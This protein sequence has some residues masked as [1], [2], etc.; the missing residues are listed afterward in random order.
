MGIFKDRLE[1]KVPPHGIRVFIVRPLT[2]TPQFL[3]TSRHITGAYSIKSLDWDASKY[4]LSGT[5]ETVPGAKYS[6]FIYL[7]T[8]VSVSRVDANADDLY[9]NIIEGNLLELSF[10]GQEEPV[11]WMVEFSK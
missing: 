4:S 9:H 5:S 10:M 7:P 11:N 6:L 2:D 8:G 1:T 3:S